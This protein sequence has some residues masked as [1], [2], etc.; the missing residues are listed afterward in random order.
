VKYRPTVE[1]PACRYAWAIP[2]SGCSNPWCIAQVNIT[3][4][5]R[6][7]ISLATAKV[8]ADRAALAERQRMLEKS[9]QN[10]SC[11]G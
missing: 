5:R 4:E 6:E 2:E 3:L 10:T 7:A 1:C 11:L 8:A 9:F